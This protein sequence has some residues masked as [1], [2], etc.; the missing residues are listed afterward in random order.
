VHYTNWST[1][2]FCISVHCSDAFEFEF[3]DSSRADPSWD[4]LILELKPRRIFFMYS[5]FSSK[6][7]FFFLLL[8]ISETENREIFWKKH[9]FQFSSLHFFLSCREK[10]MGR[11]ELKILHLEL[12]LKPAWLGLITSVQSTEVGRAF[13]IHFQKLF[14]N[15]VFIR[16]KIARKFTFYLND[17][18]W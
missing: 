11:V 17:D 13:L 12:W 4:I 8:P 15:K 7:I 10:A 5:F 1:L 16:I 14:L 18:I 3:F 2:N 9:E 6:Y